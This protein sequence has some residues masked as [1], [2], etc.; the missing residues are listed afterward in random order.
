MARAAHDPGEIIAV[1]DDADRVIGKSTREDAHAR[2]LLH[3]ES[4]CYLLNSK[5]QVLLQKRR[6]NGLWDH[7]CAG[8]FSVKETYEQG[9]IREFQEELG[10]LLRRSEL[11]ELGKERLSV[12]SH[13]K[14]NNRFAR[15]FL[16]K[17]D[18]APSDISFDSL[19]IDSVRFYDLK[20][21]RRLL[22]SPDVI[23]TAANLIINKYILRLLR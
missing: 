22:S 20:Q 12:T 9:A 11:V 4:C 18:I 7:S 3:R 21:L 16:V 14:I 15:I 17:K 13:K 5:G 6:D 10:L 23:T 8:H 2:G 1:V 19:E